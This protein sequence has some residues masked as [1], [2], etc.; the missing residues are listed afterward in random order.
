LR[1]FRRIQY[2]KDLLAF[3]RIPTR[4]YNMADI[5]IGAQLLWGVVSVIFGLL[6]LAAPKMLNYLIALYFIITGILAIVP[7]FM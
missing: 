1:D 3:I 2:K 7:S 5:I 4:E 6:I